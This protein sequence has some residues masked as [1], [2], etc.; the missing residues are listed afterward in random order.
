MMSQ[1]STGILEFNFATKR[2]GI[3]KSN[4]WITEGLHCGE[5]FEVLVN[6]KWVVDRIE[7]SNDW[8]LVFSKLKGDELSHLKVRY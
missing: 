5:V 8:Y 1:K 3:K 4:K 6:D 7:Y 2:Y